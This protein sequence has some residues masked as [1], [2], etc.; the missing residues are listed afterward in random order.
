MTNVNRVNTYLTIF[1]MYAFTMSP[2]FGQTTKLTSDISAEDEVAGAVANGQAYDKG[3]FGDWTLRCVKSDKVPE[4]CQLFQLMKDASGSPV[5]EFNLNTLSKTGPVLAG[6]NV[7]TPLETLLPEGLTIRVGEND[8]KRYPFA[9]CVKIGCVARI[10]LTAEDLDYYR[11]KKCCSSN[12]G[13]SC[14]TKSATNSFTFFKRVHCRT[15]C[16]VK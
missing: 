12:D 1:F 3:F 4:M 7:I 9:F 13:T 11:K 10:E 14:N 8:A 6:A 5:A 2:L 15:R 16:Y